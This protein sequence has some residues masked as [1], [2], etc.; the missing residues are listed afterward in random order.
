MKND[1][2]VFTRHVGSKRIPFKER[3]PQI[4]AL[5]KNM[6]ITMGTPAKNGAFSNREFSGLRAKYG[7]TRF[8]EGNNNLA[9]EQAIE[10]DLK[11]VE[12]YANYAEINLL[13]LPTVGW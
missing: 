8:D 3:V 13:K 11:N 12:D 9:M 7:S 5:L 1:N 2:P 10:L 4:R 6:K